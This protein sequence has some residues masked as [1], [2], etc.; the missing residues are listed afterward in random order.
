VSIFGRFLAKRRGEGEALVNTREIARYY[1]GMTGGNDYLNRYFGALEATGST[2]NFLKQNR[3]FSLYQA[4]GHVL[5]K[6]LPG[7]IAECGCW[8]GHST[9]LMAGLLK[10]ADW[11]GTLRVF[12]SFEGG[13]SDKTTEDRRLR[14]N[15]DP[16]ETERQKQKFASD[17]GAVQQV[18]APYPF[19]ALHK[20]WIPEV[21][22]GALPSDARFSLVH[23]DVDLYQPT[24]DSLRFFYPRMV[25]GGLIV[26]DD[27]GSTTFP[28]SRIAT[29]EFLGS[30][31]PTLFL[32]GHLQ[33][34]VLL[35]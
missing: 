14:G 12:D 28:G 31:T 26:L 20:G 34:A 35:V 32:E 22:D 9:Y 10:E 4:V 15:T 30:V 11:T 1:E 7:D 3:F 25:K 16:A 6:G 33:S 23:L 5:K 21:F 27:Y 17:F 24:L 2:D 18:L 19:V 8:K 29:D 13:L